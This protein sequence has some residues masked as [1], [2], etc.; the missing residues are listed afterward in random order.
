MNTLKLFLFSFAA[1]IFCCSSLHAL[2]FFDIMN[3]EEIY[4]YY[5]CPEVENLYDTKFLHVSNDFEGKRRIRFHNLYS[6]PL[7]P[8]SVDIFQI[9]EEALTF[10]K[11][12]FLKVCEEIYRILK[13]GGLFRLSVPDYRSDVLANRVER[14]VTGKIISD[15][16]GSKPRHWFPIYEEL[17]ELLKQTRFYQDGTLHYFHYY[18]PSGKAVLNNIDYSKGWITRTPDHDKRVSDPVRPLSIVV[19]MYK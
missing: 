10:T 13:P 18:S 4:L 15:P 9:E 11:E 2:T 14:D 12:E 3:D 17:H 19:D 8:E 5:G 16:Y 6:I 7:E 1:I